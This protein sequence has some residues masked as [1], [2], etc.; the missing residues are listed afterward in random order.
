MRRM[1]LHATGPD[2]ASSGTETYTGMDA[3]LH[4][5][6][7]G[8]GASINYI[9]VKDLAGWL[10]AGSKLHSAAAKGTPRAATVTTQRQK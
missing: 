3:L 1:P 7:R 9:A 4:G 2:S 8:A 6:A 10:A 5:D